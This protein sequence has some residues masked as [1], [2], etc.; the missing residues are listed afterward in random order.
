MRIFLPARTADQDALRLGA[1]RLQLPSGRTV[2]GVSSEARA[3]APDE[4]TEELE[5]DAIQDAVYAGLL[6]ADAPDRRLVVL[7]G[8][9]PDAA[10][11]P[12]TEESGMYGLRL[13]RDETF[14]LASVHVTELDAQ[15]VADDDTD[16]ALLWFDAGEAPRALDYA[17]ERSR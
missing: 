10:V 16:P 2:W 11:G 17:A 5:Y 3:Q 4:D 7:A 13:E 8:D 12:D 15:S 9:L 14:A 1:R 6:E